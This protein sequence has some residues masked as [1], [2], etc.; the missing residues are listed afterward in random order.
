MLLHC[1]GV[2]ETVQ[3][4]ADDNTVPSRE[5]HDNFGKSIDSLD[6]IVASFYIFKDVS[7]YR[8]TKKCFRQKF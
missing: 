5:D 2:H 8:V 3:F 1:V 6:G 4:L 7:L